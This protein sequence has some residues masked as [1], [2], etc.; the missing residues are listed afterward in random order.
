MYSAKYT[1]CDKG[2]NLI[3]FPKRYFLAPELAWV[4]FSSSGEPPPLRRKK[5]TK[6]ST[7]YH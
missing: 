3:N 4:D 2:A 7:I 5:I 1:Q 6:G